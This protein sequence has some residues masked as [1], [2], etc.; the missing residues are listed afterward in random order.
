MLNNLDVNW[1]YF[2]VLKYA[3]V[4]RPEQLM[5]CYLAAFHDQKLAQILCANP[6]LLGK[7]RGNYVWKRLM[8]FVYT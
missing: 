4:G 8:G 1:C 7:N 2:L 6:A 3:P 5:R